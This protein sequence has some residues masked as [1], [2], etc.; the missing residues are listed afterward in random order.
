LLKKD[1]SQFIS[2]IY[3]HLSDEELL[4]E[5]TYDVEIIGTVTKQ[6]YGDSIYRE[7][8]TN[9]ILEFGTI[10]S[11]CSGINVI[12]KCLSEEKIT[13]DNMR[14]LARFTDYDYLSYD[15]EIDIN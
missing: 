8:A 10:V 7:T 5:Q 14:Q 1:A 9:H 12:S 3:I 2:G 15:S 6:H 4:P 11:S 13:L